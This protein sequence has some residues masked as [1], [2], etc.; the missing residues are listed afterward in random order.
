[1]IFRFKSFV[2]ERVFDEG[3]DLFDINKFNIESLIKLLQE[4]GDISL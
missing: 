4:L 3:D 2:I 1:L